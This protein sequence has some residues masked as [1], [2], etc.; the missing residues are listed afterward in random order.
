MFDNIGRKIKILAKTICWIGIVCSVIIAMIIFAGADK[1]L[2]SLKAAYLFFG[3]AFLILGPLFSWIS[4]F[5]L[6]GFGELV[7]T[8]C[9]VAESTWDKADII[10]EKYELT[11]KQTASNISNKTRGVCDICN[12]ENVRL[13]SVKIVDN[14]GTR[15]KNVCDS[16]RAYFEH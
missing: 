8:I 1:A 12:S 4:S 3:F 7:E 11:E 9:E 10:K 15:Y 5:V 13:S 16:C 6:Y 14:T 2:D